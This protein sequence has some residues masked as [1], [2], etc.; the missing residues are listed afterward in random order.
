MLDSEE[1]EEDRPDEQLLCEE[2][3]TLP[4]L[5]GAHVEKMAAGKENYVWTIVFAVRTYTR[6]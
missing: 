6:K 1:E 2:E 3:A 4:R 5:V